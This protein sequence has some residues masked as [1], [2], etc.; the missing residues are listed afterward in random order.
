MGIDF[1]A[2]ARRI[3]WRNIAFALFMILL[4]ALPAAWHVQVTLVGGL[5]AILFLLVNVAVMA[6]GMTRSTPILP[7]MIG[8]A[9]ALLGGATLME[10]LMS[11][12]S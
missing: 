6:R 10:V 7:A 1:R 4:G 2:L 3:G 8:I 11:R 5:A 9:L 12:H